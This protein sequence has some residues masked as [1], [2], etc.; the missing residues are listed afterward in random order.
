MVLSPNLTDRE[1]AKFFDRDGDTVVRIQPSSTSQFIH[2]NAAALTPGTVIKTGSG[3]FVRA[4]VASP[5]FG[6]AAIQFYDGLS[7]AG[8]LIMSL[9][10]TDS[11]VPID[12]D[13]KFA[14]GLTFVAAGSGFSLVVIYD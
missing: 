3:V 1:F 9:D 4:I 2:I 8:T 10:L 12:V 13:I 11:V 5:G 14:T 7:D 6:T